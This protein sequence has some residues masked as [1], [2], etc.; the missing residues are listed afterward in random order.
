MF[1]KFWNRWKEIRANE[2][3]KARLIKVLCVAGVIVMPFLSVWV[4]AGFAK[5]MGML[6]ALVITGISLVGS[7]LVS[8]WLFGWLAHYVL[9]GKMPDIDDWFDSTIF[10]EWESYQAK[11]TAKSHAAPSHIKTTIKN[12]SVGGDIVGGNKF[13][14]GPDWLKKE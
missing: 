3:V 2:P 13:D 5:A 1:N 8:N 11:T 7:G 6:V 10:D 9:T 14:S 12:C 4:W